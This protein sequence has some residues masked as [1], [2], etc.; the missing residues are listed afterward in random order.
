MKWVV[1][2]VQA[3]LTLV[4]LLAGGMKLSG[5]PMQVTAFTEIYGYPVVFMYVVGVIEVLAAIGLFIGYW[6]PK[7]SLYSAGLLALTMAGAVLTHFQAGQGLAESV[8]ALILLALALLVFFGY[9]SSL[10]T[11]S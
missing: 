3:L 4:F 1:R 6:K 2:I 5:N 7:V 11:G 8:A 10:Q 9:R